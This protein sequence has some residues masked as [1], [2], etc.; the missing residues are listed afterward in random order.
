M[1]LTTSGRYL[2]NFYALTLTPSQ[3]EATETFTTVFEQ[4]SSSPK[5]VFINEKAFLRDGRELF[6]M[7]RLFSDCG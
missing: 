7:A 3:K 4:I 1:L 2:F 5:A 6:T